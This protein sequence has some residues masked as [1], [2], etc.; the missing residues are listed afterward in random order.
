MH[1]EFQYKVHKDWGRVFVKSHIP[2][3]FHTAKIGNEMVRR[4]KICHAVNRDM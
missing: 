3:R 1:L 4:L 2:C